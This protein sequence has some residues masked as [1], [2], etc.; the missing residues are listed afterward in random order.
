MRGSVQVDGIPS[1][2]VS[3]EGDTDCEVDACG[4]IERCCGG[5]LDASRR[6]SSTV[7]TVGGSEGIYPSE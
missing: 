7:T 5:Q 6:A 3:V 2:D 4:H 1:V